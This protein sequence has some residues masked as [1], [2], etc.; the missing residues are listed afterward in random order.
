M[1]GGGVLI[2]LSTA[3]NYVMPAFIINTEYTTFIMNMIV[4][5]ALLLLLKVLLNEPYKYKLYIH[6]PAPLKYFVINGPV[7]INYMQIVEK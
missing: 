6:H 1:G 7:I 3:L 5:E 4:L 2:Y